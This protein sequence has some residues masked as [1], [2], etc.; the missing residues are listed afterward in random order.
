MVRIFPYA[1]V[2]FASFEVYKRMLS[3]LFE[4]SSSPVAGHQPQQV[5]H[6]L[7]FVAGSMAGVTSVLMTYPLDLVRARLASVVHTKEV[8]APPKLAGSNVPTTILGTIVYV[9]RNEG[10]LAGLYRGITPTV[11]AMIPYGGCNFYMFERLKHLCVS[12]APGVTCYRHREDSDKLTLNVPAKLLCGGV[13]GAIGQTAIYPLDVA[14]RRMQLAMTSRE[15]LIY[16]ESFL[17][18]LALTYRSHGVI[19]G[20][21]R[22]MSVNYIRAIPMVAVSFCT[23]E[24]LKQL[25]GLE[26]GV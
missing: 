6:E 25:A 2:Q 7:K 19:R 11:L 13:A 9:F 17:Q 14:R 18:T 5:N 1:A 23:Y 15:T 26:T 22:G 12:V 16:S 24:L 21:Y 3:G 10:G 8:A 4:Q 20:L